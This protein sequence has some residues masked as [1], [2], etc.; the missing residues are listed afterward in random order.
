MPAP[1][2]VFSLC[3][4]AAQIASTAHTTR[5]TLKAVP[6]MAGGLR[7]GLFDLAHIV[8]GRLAARVSAT[9]TFRIA[10][11]PS[12]RASVQGWRPLPAESQDEGPIGLSPGQLVS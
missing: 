4:E 2:E 12:R 7:R 9:E 6:L 8:A 1:S 3:F 11:S 5:A 10:K